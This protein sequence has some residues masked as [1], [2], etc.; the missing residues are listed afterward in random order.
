[1]ILLCAVASAIG[2]AGVIDGRVVDDRSRNV[3]P[4]ATVRLAKAAFE[5]DDSSRFH[6][7]DLA[8]GQISI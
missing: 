7:T 4:Y 3:I 8:R 5:T 2:L 6:V 1:M